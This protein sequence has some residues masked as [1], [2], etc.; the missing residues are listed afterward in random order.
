MIIKTKFDKGESVWFFYD[1]KILNDTI[2]SLSVDFYLEL[3]VM[4]HLE[5]KDNGERWKNEDEL[6]ETKYELIKYLSKKRI[7]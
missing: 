7:Q 5:I 2:E 3:S 1:G 6:F 4:Y